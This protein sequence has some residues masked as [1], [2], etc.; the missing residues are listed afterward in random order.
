MFAVVG[1]AALMAGPAIA[2]DWARPSGASLDADLIWVYLDHPVSVDCSPPRACYAKSQ[3]VLA[4]VRCHRRLVSVGRIVSMNLNGDVVNDVSFDISQV[5]RIDPFLSRNDTRSTA[6]QVV[7]AVC[8]QY[9]ER[10]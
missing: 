7:D 9:Y 5:P 1:L 4:S 6:R 2:A 10:D 8:G 3:W